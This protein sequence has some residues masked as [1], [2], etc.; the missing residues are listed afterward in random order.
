LG[1]RRRSDTILVSNIN[2]ADQGS[3]DV[4]YGTPS[5]PSKKS[6]SLRS[7][8]SMVARLKLRE[9]DG[10]ATPPVVEPVA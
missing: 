2:D 5:A 7:R 9:I 6:K 3:T 1:A 10:R 8:G 4:V